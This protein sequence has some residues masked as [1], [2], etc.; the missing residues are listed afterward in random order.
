MSLPPLRWI[1]DEP[2]VY[3]PG[4][5][6]LHR[7]SCPKASGDELAEGDELLLVW[8]SD[9]PKLRAEGDDGPPL[10]AS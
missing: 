10:T 7:P 6:E 4:T 9:E 2:L 8:A 5:R 3:D 1:A